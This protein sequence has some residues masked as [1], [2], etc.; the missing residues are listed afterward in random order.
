MVPWGGCPVESGGDGTGFAGG[1]DI[2]YWNDRRRHLKDLE[3][4]LGRKPIAGID[5]PT[6]EQMKLAEDFAKKNH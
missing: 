5:Y 1:V 3:K 6:D 2:R 4:D